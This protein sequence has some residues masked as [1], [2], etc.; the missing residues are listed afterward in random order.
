MPATI[1]R[2]EA[3]GVMP[4][5]LVYRALQVFLHPV[6]YLLSNHAAKSIGYKHTHHVALL[7]QASLILLIGSTTGADEECVCLGTTQLSQDDAP[8]IEI[9]LLWHDEI[10]ELGAEPLTHVLDNGS[11]LATGVL[12][13]LCIVIPHLLENI[14]R[15][16]QQVIVC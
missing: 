2:R 11:R 9:R 4:L 15:G 14:G 8:H 1:T 6:G 7:H 12:V 5:Q 10:A 3:V 13:G 16:Y